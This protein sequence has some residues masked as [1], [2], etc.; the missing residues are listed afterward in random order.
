MKILTN[1]L[2]LIAAFVN[3]APVS[4]VLSA[5]VLEGLYGITLEDPNLVILMRHRAVLFG[6]VGL[7]WNPMLILIAL[8]VWT[9]AGQ[10]AR[11]VRSRAAFGGWPSSFDL[12]GFGRDPFV[13]D[14]QVAEPERAPRRRHVYRVGPW[15]VYRDES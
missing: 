5:D 11:M 6:I 3:L 4:G 2:F 1:A 15:L 7:L 14:S 9:G 13:Y 8:F 10:E 12:G